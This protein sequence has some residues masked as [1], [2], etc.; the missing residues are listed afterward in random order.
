MNKIICFYKREA[1]GTEYVLYEE[2]GE[3]HLTNGIIDWKNKAEK[4]I[5]YPDMKKVDS[6]DTTLMLNRL[7]K[8]YPFS[9]VISLLSELRFNFKKG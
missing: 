9:G 8:F 4:Y 7:K 6:I 3:K 5:T 1:D 2:D